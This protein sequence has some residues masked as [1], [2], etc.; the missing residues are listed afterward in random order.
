MLKT[1][2]AA[3]ALA[4][5]FVGTANAVP[6]VVHSCDGGLDS[7]RWLAEPVR[8]FANGDIIVAHVS[9]EEPAGAPEHLI[10]YVAEINAPISPAFSSECYAISAEHGKNEDGSEYSRGFYGLKSVKDIRAS[11][12]DK[13]GLLLSI[14]AY[15]QDEETA[16]NVPA[17]YVTVRINRANGISVTT[18]DDGWTP[19]QPVFG[20]G[21]PR[22]FEW[23]EPH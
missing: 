11:Y 16:K 23:R 12:N 9:T 17:G 3:V 6:A 13:T 5:A 4:T 14:P 7:I 18:E 15:K 21:H 1:L 19:R 20:E 2:L 10:I 22:P 8:V